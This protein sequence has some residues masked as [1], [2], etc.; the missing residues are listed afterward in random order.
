M[1]ALPKPEKRKWSFGIPGRLFAISIDKT[2]LEVRSVLSGKLRLPICALEL[3]KEGVVLR[4]SR[5]FEK[6]KHLQAI[7]TK[8]IA[9]SAGM[10]LRRASPLLNIWMN[11]NVALAKGAIYYVRDACGPTVWKRIARSVL[12]RIGGTAKVILWDCD[13]TGI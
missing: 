1:L 8:L 9:K 11:S 2:K 4:N 10:V 13:V 5:F 3:K 6:K 12:A 7:P